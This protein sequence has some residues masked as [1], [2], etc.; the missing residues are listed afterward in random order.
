M[1]PGS[2]IMVNREECAR[3]FSV[4]DFASAYIRLEGGIVLDFRIAWYMHL[5]TPGDTIIMGTKGSLRIP[6]TDCWNGTF[7]KPMT[8]YHDVAGK[9]VQTEIP[10]LKSEGKLFDKKIRSFLNAIIT[11]SKARCLRI[12]SSTTRPSST[13]SCAPAR[14][15]TRC[16]SRSL[17]FDGRCRKVPLCPQDTGGQVS[18]GIG[19]GI[20]ETA[21]GTIVSGGHVRL[22]AKGPVEGADGAKAHLL[23]HF[24]LFVQ[25]STVCGGKARD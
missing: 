13:A 15:A 1:V 23:P 7:T 2:L 3:K 9:P 12:R 8:L 17:K 20:T 6:S 11:G 16:R 24:V 4:D 19:R 25:Y 10:L 5:D 21:I 22:L 18:Y 14:L